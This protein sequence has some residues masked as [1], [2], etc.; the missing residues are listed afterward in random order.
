MHEQKYSLI[1]EQKIQTGLCEVT[2]S[3]AITAEYRC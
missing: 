2:T 3:I 1:I